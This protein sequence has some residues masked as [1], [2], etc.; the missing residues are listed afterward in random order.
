MDCHARWLIVYFDMGVKSWNFWIPVIYGFI[1]IQFWFCLCDL[2]EQN[3][4]FI[5]KLRAFSKSEQ[6]LQKQEWRIE[7]RL[8]LYERKTYLQK[9][10]VICS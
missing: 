1:I 10:S 5:L 3:I 9:T 7:G 2:L 4:V 6:W 8:W